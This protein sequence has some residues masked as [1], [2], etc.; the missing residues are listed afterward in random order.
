MPVNHIT[1]KDSD[2]NQWCCNSHFHNLEQ[3]KALTVSQHDQINPCQQ[4]DV[5]AVGLS[6]HNRSSPSSLV[7]IDNVCAQV[8][9]CW[10]RNII[11]AEKYLALEGE[12][13]CGGLTV[14][15]G[16]LCVH[17]LKIIPGWVERRGDT[18]LPWE[19]G[20]IYRECWTYSEHSVS[21]CWAAA[22]KNLGECFITLQQT[23][24]I[25]HLL[26]DYQNIKKYNL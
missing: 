11:D 17:W 19:L 1:I 6:G 12:M 18:Q 15:Q 13:W 9:K 16:V 7:D 10:W 8:S 4:T 21:A 26:P 14:D 25:V 24:N 5:G 20:R 3:R 23:V 22:G 2:K